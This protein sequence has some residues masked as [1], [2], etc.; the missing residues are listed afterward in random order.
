[1]HAVSD[2]PFRGPE[3]QFYEPPHLFNKIQ[4]RKAEQ[5]F[6]VWAVSVTGYFSLA[7]SVWGHFGHDISV[8][9]QLI[10][11]VYLNYIGRGNVTLAGVI[12]TP[13]EES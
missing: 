10:T 8:H 12:P 4:C 6:S 13:F 5:D 9:E 7:V 11:F 1:V 2:E 3:A